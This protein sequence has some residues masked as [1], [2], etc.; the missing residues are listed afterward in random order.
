MSEEANTETSAVA[1]EADL[2]APLSNGPARV[3]LGALGIAFNAVENKLDAKFL[4]ALAT[5]AVALVSGILWFFGVGNSFAAAAATCQN[6]GVSI[7]YTPWVIAGLLAAIIV[8]RLVWRWRRTRQINKVDRHADFK[9]L[10]RVTTCL[11]KSPTEID[12][13]YRYIVRPRKNG[14]KTFSLQFS[15]TG[16]RKRFDIRMRNPSI[17]YEFVKDSDYKDSEI[18]MTFKKSLNKSDEQ[19][20]DF[21]VE[22]VAEPGG[23][24]SPFL[25]LAVNS[26]KYPKWNTVLTTIFA[27]GVNPASIHREQYFS[28]VSEQAVK[29]QVVELDADRKHRWRI[30]IRPG[31]RFVIRWA[32]E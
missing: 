1:T 19:I 31:W 26:A 2:W 13:Y 32:Y 11:I 12:Y 20:I 21:C 29:T 16:K 30:P 7:S 6:L 3:R 10:H 22:T 18:I 28:H 23:E 17:S 27:P 8:A 25:G 4:I 24:A 5:S 15:W 9:I 14:V